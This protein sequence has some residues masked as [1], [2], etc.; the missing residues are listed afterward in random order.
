VKKIKRIFI[1]YESEENWINTMAGKGLSLI[2]KRGIEFIFGETEK[3]KFVYRKEFLEKDANHFESLNYIEIVKKNFESELVSKEKNWVYFRNRTNSI[4]YELYSDL[5]WKI[6]HDI[7]IR[8]IWLRII[9]AMPIY[10]ISIAI[11]CNLFFGL[12]YWLH[13]KISLIIYII[14][15]PISIYQLKYFNRRINKMKIKLNLN[16]KNKN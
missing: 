14:I 16:K 12:K 2:N 3:N 6:K 9:W 10:F 8:R 13:F 5:N 1:N 4:P 7:K 11:F 15:L